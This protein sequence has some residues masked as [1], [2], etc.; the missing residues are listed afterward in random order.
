MKKIVNV[1]QRSTITTTSGA[2]IATYVASPTNIARPVG[3][4]GILH[5]YSD[6]ITYYSDFAHALTQNGFCVFGYD[7]RGKGNTPGDQAYIINRAID[8][9]DFNEIKSYICPKEK[10]HIFGNSLGGCLALHMG[11][12]NSNI[13]KSII[14]INPA[15][16]NN[17]KVIQVNKYAFRLAKI[18]MKTPIFDLFTFKAMDVHSITKDKEMTSKMEN[19]PLFYKG[20]LK[21]ATA[22]EIHHLM[23]EVKT[24]VKA[25]KVPWLLHL[26]SKDECVN[27]NITRNCFDAMILRDKK[28]HEYNAD[29]VL[30]SKEKNYSEQMVYNTLPWLYSHL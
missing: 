22:R 3:Y 27:S 30:Y 7:R 26:S 13:I 6:H 20:P 12:K 24:N 5:G 25:M 9:Q 15:I 29:H 1:F 11:I 2:K 8:T 18:L 16:E 28:L 14:T 21:G 23:E 19:D 10:V 4:V 17:D